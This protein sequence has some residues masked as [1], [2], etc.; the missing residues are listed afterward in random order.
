M[1]TGKH[2]VSKVRTKA[3][4]AALGCI[5]VVIGCFIKSLPAEIVKCQEAGLLII[6]EV[7]SNKTRRLFSCSLTTSRICPDE[8]GDLKSEVEK[9][10]KWITSII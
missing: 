8:E 5:G 9:A 3:P 7:M 10:G 2:W 4:G 1:A 6:S